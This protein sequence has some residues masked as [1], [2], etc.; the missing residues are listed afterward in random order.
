MK[1]KFSLN[2]DMVLSALIEIDHWDCRKD[3]IM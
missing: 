1:A 2:G 3:K